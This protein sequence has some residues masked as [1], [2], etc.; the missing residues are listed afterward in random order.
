[1][2][3]VS[4]YY[5]VECMSFHSQFGMSFECQGRAAQ[6][7]QSASVS[8]DVRVQQSNTCSKEQ[9]SPTQLTGN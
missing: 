6:H 8:I 1:M 9:T 2:E 5:M 7:R 3:K 4:V